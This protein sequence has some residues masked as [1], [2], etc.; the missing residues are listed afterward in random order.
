MPVLVSIMSRTTAGS[1]TIQP[2]TARRGA[3]TTTSSQ[4]LA[5]TPLSQTGSQNST[6]HVCST[7]VVSAY[8][9]IKSKYSHAQYLE[10]M[11]NSLSLHECM[12]IFTQ[13]THQVK[14]P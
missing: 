5:L 6:E 1:D 4:P 14:V 9:E 7:T 13:P 11:K 12:V 3:H 10:W 2:A 8:Y